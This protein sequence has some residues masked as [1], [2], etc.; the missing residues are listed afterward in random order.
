M[1]DT[2]TEI[3]Q[4]LVALRTAF[5]RAGG[6]GELSLTISRRDADLL[7]YALKSYD[8]LATMRELPDPTMVG[9]IAGVEIRWRAEG[10]P[11]RRPVR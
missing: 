3:I 7:L 1:T 2:R 9:K 10:Y 4:A 6:D 5:R 11:K 8:A